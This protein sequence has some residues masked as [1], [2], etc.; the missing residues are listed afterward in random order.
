MSPSFTMT[1]RYDPG[2]LHSSQM[3]SG[4]IGYHTK[5]ECFEVK[6]FVPFSLCFPH[7]TQMYNKCHIHIEIESPGLIYIELSSKTKENV[8]SE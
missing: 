8:E 7:E 1:V 6:H 4:E 3:E 2:I 5:A